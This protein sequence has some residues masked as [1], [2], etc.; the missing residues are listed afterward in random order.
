MGGVKQ[1]LG[2]QLGLQL[3]KGHRQVAH[4]L[5]GHGIAVELVGAVPWEHRHT[6]RHHHLHTVFGAEPEFHGAAL[7]HHAADGALLVFQ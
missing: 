6:A 5:R 4:A 7:E 2:V 3:L 1:A